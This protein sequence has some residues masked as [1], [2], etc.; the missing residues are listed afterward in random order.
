MGPTLVFSQFQVLLSHVWELKKK[1]DRRQKRY[2]G[3]ERRSRTR[4]EEREEEGVKRKKKKIIIKNY[5]KKQ[6]QNQNK[7]KQACWFQTGQASFAGLF[8]FSQLRGPSTALLC[9]GP[10]LG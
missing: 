9:L 8:G 7:T 10:A 4:K 3:R 5:F 6:N 2:K 1:K